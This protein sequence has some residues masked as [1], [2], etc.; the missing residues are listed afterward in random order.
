MVVYVD[1]LFA[2]NLLMDLTIIWAA[3]V[4]LKKRIRPLR[5]TLG[6]AAGAAAYIAVLYLPYING[7]VQ[8]IVIILSILL[9]LI[10]AYGPCGI[11]EIIRLLLM[12]L[13]LSF[14]IAGIMLGILCLKSFGIGCSTVEIM[15]NFSYSI[16]IFSSAAVY[17]AIKLCGKAIRKTA[18]DK[19]EYFDIVLRLGENS[20]E[21]RALA[22]TGN[23]LKD[24]LG[25][26]DIVIAE[27]S[28]VKGLLPNT[29]FNSDGVL[30]FKALAETPLKNRIRLI[31]FSSL[32]N[33]NG[34]L[35]GIKADYAEIKF[36]EGRTVKKENA[37]IG[38][39]GERLDK[40]GNFNA[41]ANYEIIL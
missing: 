9:S 27:Y 18:C 36:R 10:L 26:N 13:V 14:V 32:G 2:I 35:L 23:S 6:A 24:S 15:E 37:V 33:P 31:P 3:G 19:R 20:V 34:M 4:L 38:I 25:G 28:A 17:A 11:Y 41:I 30:M 1:V 5:L 8:L 39:Y 16:L 40:T 7:A 22:D 21:V 29:E 12:S